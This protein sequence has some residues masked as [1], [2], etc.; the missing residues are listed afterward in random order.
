MFVMKIDLSMCQFMLKIKKKNKNTDALI[1]CLLFL[2]EEKVDAFQLKGIIVTD[3]S[4]LC[5]SYFSL[6]YWIW[7]WS[8]QIRQFDSRCCRSTGVTNNCKDDCEARWA[9]MS[10]NPQYR[11]K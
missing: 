4:D 8:A 3:A 9:I 10:Q 6:G 5:Y 11:C 7:S 2:T 1:F